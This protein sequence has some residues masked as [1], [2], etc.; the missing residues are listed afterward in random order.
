[1]TLTQKTTHVTEGQGR[2]ITQFRGLTNFEAWLE[3]YLEQIQDIENVL[4]DMLDVWE[5]IENQEGDV[6][7]LIGRIVGQDRE[8]RTDTIFI[9]WIKARLAVNR[10]SGLPDELMTVLGLVAPNNEHDYTE[11]Y[12]AAYIMRLLGAFSEDPTEVAAI[13]SEVRAGGV[14]QSSLEY[15]TEAHADTFSFSDD[16]T[17]DASVTQGWGIV[18]AIT[19]GNFV[20]WTGDDPDDWIVTET[21]PNSEVSEVGSAEGHG[22]SGTGACNLY[23]DGATLALLQQSNVFESGVLYRVEFDVTKLTSGS[24]QF[25]NN[26]FDIQETISTEGH[27]TYTFTSSGVSSIQFVVLATQACDA[28]I[29]NVE[30]TPGGVWADAERI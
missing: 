29:D 10:A 7:D 26:L 8:E 13:L 4:F 21:I 20:A 3:S 22:G 17:I 14:G 2:L 11:S 27:H 9:R 12:P 15:T 16:D 24:F 1:M 18:D 5:N 23:G 30:I 6:L 19:N 28:T 25:R